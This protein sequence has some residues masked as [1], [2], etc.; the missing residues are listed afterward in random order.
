MVKN[1]L[2]DTDVLIEHLKGNL[3]VSKF[4][5]KLRDKGELCVSVLSQAE[6]YAGMREEE[7]EITE[8]LFDTLKSFDVSDEIAKVGGIYRRTYKDSHGTGLI[9]G[10]IGATAKTYG[11]V[12]VTANASH[13]PMPKLKLLSPK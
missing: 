1:F 13:F 6:V 3:T 10:M 9:D 12:L 7:R 5:E 4:L 11:L 2:V 8:F